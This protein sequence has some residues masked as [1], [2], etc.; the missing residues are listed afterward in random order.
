MKRVFWLAG[1]PSGDLHA[2]IVIE[3]LEK[4]NPEMYNYGVGGPLMQ[5]AGFRSIFSFSR[6]NVMGF[7]EVIK[8]LR[9]FYKTEKQIAKMLTVKKPDLV[10][11]VD[12]PGFNMRIAKIANELLIP[13]IWYIAPQFWAW[14]HK[15]V[16]KLE[17]YCEFVATIHKFEKNLLD[18]HNLKSEFVGNP[19]VEEI[20]IDISRKKFAKIFELDVD[21][22]WI[23]FM[24]GSRQM[25][26][27]KMLPTFIKTIE[28][29]DTVNYQFLISKSRSVNHKLFMDKIDNSKAKIFVIDGHNYEMMKYSQFLIITSGTATLEA[30]YLQTP[31]MIVYKT[32]MLSYAIGKRLVRIKNIGLPN[33]ISEREIVPEL[34]QEEVNPQ[35]IK[36]KIDYYL[37]NAGAMREMKENLVE[38]KELVSDLKPS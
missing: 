12:Y 28:E 29:Y 11:L 15:R 19:I 18:M 32:S 23:G 5:K 4:R 7:W 9:F 27:D 2:S 25:E 33:I 21:K 6:F 22:K 14:K 10:V 36:S 30:A 34:L 31:L 35:N 37:E 24:P 1:D 8:H 38:I 16:Y 13:I 20:K 26:I 3:E 17:E